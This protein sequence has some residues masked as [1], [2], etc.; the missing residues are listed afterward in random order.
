[1]AQ[2]SAPFFLHCSTRIY[3][4]LTTATILFLLLAPVLAMGGDAP[5]QEA[6]RRERKSSPQATL[7]FPRVLVIRSF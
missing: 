6:N 1:M 3:L 2:I 4:E 5:T 7:N